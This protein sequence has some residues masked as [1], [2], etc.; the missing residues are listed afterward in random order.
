MNI[1]KSILLTALAAISN[2]VA[3]AQAIKQNPNIWDA[4]DD[5]E[6]IKDLSKKRS[7]HNVVRVCK[8]GRLMQVAQHFSHSSHSSHSS[9][10]SSAG[11]GMNGA[12]QTSSSVNSTYSSNGTMQESET[13]PRIARKVASY[14][15]GDANIKNGD[16]GNDVNELI[17]LLKNKKELGKYKVK[18]KNGFPLYEDTLVKIVKRIQKKF[19]MSE[20][21][22]VT[23]SFVEKLKNEK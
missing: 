14:K 16:Y 23:K 11:S 22:V 1:I 9:H 19:K 15:L 3:N 21:G 10:Y 7:F 18:K 2:N 12:H 5:D 4:N 6:Q 20:D 8:S 17:N 13:Q